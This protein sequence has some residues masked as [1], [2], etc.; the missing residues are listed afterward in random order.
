MDSCRS[1]PRKILIKKNHNQRNTQPDQFLPTDSSGLAQTTFENRVYLIFY[2]TSTFKKTLNLTHYFNNQSILG[3]SLLTL[4]YENWLH[5]I[6]HTLPHKP[7]QRNMLFP[8]LNSLNYVK[9][10]KLHPPY[11]IMSSMCL[12][13]HGRITRQTNQS[14]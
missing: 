1:K 6:T 8:N 13:Q 9:L 5:K 4:F 2:Q 3:H 12:F 11:S 14:S 10:E 7:A